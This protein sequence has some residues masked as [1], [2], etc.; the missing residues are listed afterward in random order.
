MYCMV[1]HACSGLVPVIKYINS[2]GF[3]LGV[4][5]N[6][7]GSRVEMLYNSEVGSSLVH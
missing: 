2:K 3:K 4:V 7:L 6:T 1:L 5:S